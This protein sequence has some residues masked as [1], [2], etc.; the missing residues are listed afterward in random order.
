[1]NGVVNT[2]TPHDSLNDGSKIIIHKNDVRSLFGNLSTGDTHRKPDMGSFECG[3]IIRTV[4]RNADNLAKRAKGFDKDLLIFRGRPRQNLKTRNDLEA[5]LWVKGTE[6]AMRVGTMVISEGLVPSV[7]NILHEI[8]NDLQ[9]DLLSFGNPRLPTLQNERR[10]SVDMSTTEAREQRQVIPNF[11]DGLVPFSS[12]RLGGWEYFI[13]PHDP[14]LD[15]G[16]FK[17]WSRNASNESAE[18]NLNETESKRD[19]PLVTRNTSDLAGGTTDE[20]NENLTGDLYK[21]L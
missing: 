15:E 10:R 20:H 7:K 19:T 4:T 11:G 16:A 14:Q 2:T 1:M 21:P 12:L 6:E 18:G 8:L 5:L 9:S 17:R 3:T 13:R